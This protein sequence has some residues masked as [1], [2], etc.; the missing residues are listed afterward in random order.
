[1][2]EGAVPRLTALALA[3]ELAPGAAAAFTRAL[4]GWFGPAGLV[5]PALF[6]EDHRAR[7][8]LPGGWEQG[9]MQQLMLR[10]DLAR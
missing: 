9:E 6:P 10:A 8:F 2:V 5:A 4:L 3:P 7:F 1:M